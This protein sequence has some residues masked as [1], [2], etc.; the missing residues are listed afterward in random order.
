MNGK[1]VQNFGV[2][3]LGS[4]GRKMGLVRGMGTERNMVAMTK[5]VGERKKKSKREILCLWGAP[6]KYVVS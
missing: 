5:V 4:E 1:K 2:F 3:I 6:K